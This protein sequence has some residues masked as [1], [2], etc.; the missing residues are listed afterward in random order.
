MFYE[1]IPAGFWLSGSFSIQKHAFSLFSDA[2]NAQFSSFFREIR[3]LFFF[4]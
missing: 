4:R 2:K 3:F 1:A